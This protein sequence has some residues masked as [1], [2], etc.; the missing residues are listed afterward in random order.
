[1]G[2]PHFPHSRAQRWID[3]AE[4]VGNRGAGGSPTTP[5]QPQ[6]PFAG[7]EANDLTAREQEVLG[8]LVRGTPD[9]IV[10]ARPELSPHTAREHTGRILRKFGVRTRGELQAHLFGAHYEP[11][12]AA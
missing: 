11:S 4:T 10:A 8:M 9:M 5:T 2:S 6:L 3:C 7:A 1:M 12:L